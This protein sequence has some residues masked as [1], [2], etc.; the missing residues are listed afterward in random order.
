MIY[1]ESC[2][3]MQ[4]Y[5]LVTKLIV[6]ALRSRIDFLIVAHTIFIACDSIQDEL[7]LNHVYIDQ[8]KQRLS[9]LAIVDCTLSPGLCFLVFCDIDNF[10]TQ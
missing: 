7:H 10:N 5:K 4:G 8:S 1:F 6:V 2:T 3:S 9:E